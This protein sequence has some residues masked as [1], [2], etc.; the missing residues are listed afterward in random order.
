MPKR[1]KFGVEKVEVFFTKARRDRVQYTNWKYLIYSFRAGAKTFEFFYLRNFS[2]G[3]AKIV[4]FLF[5]FRVI[6]VFEYFV[7]KFDFFCIKR[8]LLRTKLVEPYFGL[9]PKEGFYTES[10]KSAARYGRAKR[11][12]IKG[13]EGNSRYTRRVVRR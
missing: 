1:W 9:K 4:F 11:L 5:S 12:S 8:S 6:L 10:N 7:R 13:T 3:A 2:Y